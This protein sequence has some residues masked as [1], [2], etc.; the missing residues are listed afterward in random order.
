MRSDG[1]SPDE[2]LLDA[3]ELGNRCQFP[4]ELRSF[5]RILNIPL[6]QIIIE[7]VVGTQLS[8]VD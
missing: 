8:A 4:V 2:I 6:E 1:E 5:Q 7:L 3:I